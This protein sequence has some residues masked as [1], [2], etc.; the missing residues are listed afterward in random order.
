M[1]H[2]PRWRVILVAVVSAWA[3][4]FTMPNLWPA[5][6]RAALPP[7]LPKQTVNLGL[8]LRGGSYLLLEADLKALLKE[9]L[10]TETDSMGQG[11]ARRQA[12]DFVHWA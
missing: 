9:R 11:V 8:D 5:S 6:V 2:F 4:L 10:E 3:I 7:F 1:L 12:A